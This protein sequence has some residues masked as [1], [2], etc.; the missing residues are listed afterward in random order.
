MG[1]VRRIAQGVGS[2]LGFTVFSLGFGLF[3]PCEASFASETRHALWLFEGCEFG[4]QFLG[5]GV[6][7]VGGVMG[8]LVGRLLTVDI[9]G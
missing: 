8:L 2:L 3:T 4:M 7:L 5:I 6:G 1:T 9:P